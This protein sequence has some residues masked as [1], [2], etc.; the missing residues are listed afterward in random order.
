MFKKYYK[1]KKIKGITDVYLVFKFDDCFSNRRIFLPTDNYTALNP[2]VIDY[3]NNSFVFHA[4]EVKKIASFDYILSISLNETCQHERLLPLSLD[5]V[6]KSL[7]ETRESEYRKQFKDI[8]N[9]SIEVF[10]VYKKDE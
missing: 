7:G 2:V 4:N 5:F 3:T 8:I 9:S 10:Q 1:I 6:L